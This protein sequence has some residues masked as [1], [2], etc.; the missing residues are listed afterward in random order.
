MRTSQQKS[1]IDLMMET[2]GLRDTE[3]L[4]GS[5]ARFRLATSLEVMSALTKTISL[6]TW[7]GLEEIKLVSTKHHEVT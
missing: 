7:Y 4:E 3:H 6:N 1:Q 2:S 5:E